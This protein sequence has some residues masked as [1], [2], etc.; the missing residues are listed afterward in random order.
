MLHGWCRR[1]GHRESGYRVNL[2][3]ASSLFRRGNLYLRMMTCLEY[4]RE[5]SYTNC[6]WDLCMALDHS[7]AVLTLPGSGL[8]L[9][10]LLC[11]IPGAGFLLKLCR[12]SLLLPQPLA[13]GHS[14]IRHRG[15]NIRALP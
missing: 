13:L 4:K 10:G 11:Y 7:G 3:F 8:Q 12:P 1:R 14:C 9:E 6:P 5:E 15:G 2:D